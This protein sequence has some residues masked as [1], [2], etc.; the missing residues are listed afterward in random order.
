MVKVHSVIG[1]RKGWVFRLAMG[2]WI[3]GLSLLSGCST[4]DIRPKLSQRMISN[5]VGMQLVEI[6]AGSVTHGSLACDDASDADAATEESVIKRPFYITAHEITQTQFMELMGANP[7]HFSNCGGNCPVEQVSWL[8]AIEFANKLSGKEGFTP[9][10]RSGVNEVRWEQAC[11]GYRLPTEAEWMHAF[12]RSGSDKEVD[13]AQ[14]AWYAANSGYLTHP[15]GQKLPNGW[16]LY[17]MS[18]NVQEWVWDG[19]GPASDEVVGISVLRADVDRIRRG[20]GWGDIA[21]HLGLAGRGNDAPSYRDTYVG[22][23]LVRSLQP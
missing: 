15:V 22:F 18:G 12:E 8:D 19:C 9:C 13:A 11:T 6:P 21:E 5:S 16:G 2:S 23:R 3:I 4:V 10:Y 1:H 20:G 7:S 14:V 17:D